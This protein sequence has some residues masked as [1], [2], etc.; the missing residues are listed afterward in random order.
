MGLIYSPLC[1]CE[2]KRESSAH[3]LR[4]C[5]ALVLLRHAYLSSL[6]LDP[7]DIKSL[8]LGVIWNS[9]KGAGLP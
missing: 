7:E 1:R 4:E 9:S 2:E 3:I 5:E 8:S 6:F